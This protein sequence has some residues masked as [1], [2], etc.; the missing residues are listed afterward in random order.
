MA[1]LKSSVAALVREGYSGAELIERTNRLLMEYHEKRT[2]ATLLVAEIDPVANTLRVANAGHPPPVIL[3][4]S[5]PPQELM[6]SSVP[7]GSPLCSAATTERP[8]MAGDRLILYSDGLV[9]A[10][11]SE[12]EPFGYDRLRESLE[13]HHKLAADAL[14]AAVLRDLADHTGGTAADD[15]LT[16]L[17]IERSP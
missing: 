3:S 1:A 11:S 8:L 10:T 13:R 4:D 16:M 12:G 7:L 6:S 17:V 9:E 2:L 15:D 14:I 5:H